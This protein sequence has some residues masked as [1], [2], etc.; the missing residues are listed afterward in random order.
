DEYPYFNIVGEVWM[1]DQAQMAYWQRNSKI[2]A[3]QSY[4]S[5]LPSVMDFTLHDAIGIAFNETEASWDKGMIRIYENFVND[6]L[7]PDID[8]I[9]VFAENHD[10]QRFNQAH[11][12]IEDYKL[13]MTLIA[14]VR[15]IPQIY[16]GSEIGMQ[17]DK[18]KADPDIRHDFPG[19]WPNDSQNALT[20]SGRTRKQN[21]Y[22]DFT[23]KLFNWRKN[24]PVI[25]KGKTTQYIPQENVYVYF[26]YTDE[27]TIMVVLNNSTKEQSLKTDRFKESIGPWQFGQDVLSGY[28]FDLSKDIKIAPKTPLILELK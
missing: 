7:Y 2:G 25:H 4:N 22:F 23:K 1:H 17:G 13:A 27:K 20:V 6:F 10:T 12:N 21:Q 15:G 19:G 24:Q 11:P 5:H 9:L 28:Q 16:Y 26:R 8:N 14:T 18:A 3:I